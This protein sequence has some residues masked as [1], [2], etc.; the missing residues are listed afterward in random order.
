VQG[1]AHIDGADGPLLAV[2]ARIEMVA[3]CELLSYVAVYGDLAE[4]KLLKRG[5]ETRRIEPPASHANPKHK[6][7]TSSPGAATTDASWSRIFGFQNR[8]FI[9]LDSFRDVCL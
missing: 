8:L 6:A 2:H 5:V 9:P 1:V 3:V 4:L 7:K